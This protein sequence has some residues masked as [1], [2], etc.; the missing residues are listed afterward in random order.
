[1]NCRVRPV[2][3]CPKFGT[4]KKIAE[5]VRVRVHALIRTENNELGVNYGNKNGEWEGET[6]QHR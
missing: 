5:P 6:A 1:M 2:S 4:Q 3:K